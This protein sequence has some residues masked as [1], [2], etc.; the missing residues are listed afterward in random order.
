[1][2]DK[3]IT[4]K[5]FKDVLDIDSNNVYNYDYLSR[6]IDLLEQPLKLEMFVP[7]LDGVPLEKPK[8]WYNEHALTMLNE[9]E[10][11]VARVFNDNVRRYQQAEE[12]VLFEVD[13]YQNFKNLI[14]EGKR[15]K[16]LLVYD[17]YIGLTES[18]KKQIK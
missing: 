16:D 3:L 7:C 8:I 2:I 10:R 12:K 9:S 11:E 17:I 14:N 6:Y 5:E 18:A 1:M 4:V 15:I 13:L